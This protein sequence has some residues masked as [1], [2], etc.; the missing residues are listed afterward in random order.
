MTIACLRKS[1]SGARSRSI[2]RTVLFAFAALLCVLVIPAVS[3][4]S[5][6]VSRSAT[7]RPMSAPSR[8]STFTTL[9]TDPDFIDPLITTIIVA[10]FRRPVL[11]DRAPMGCWLRA[12]TFR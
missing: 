5:I 6:T 1:R 3:G 4:S 7:L 12:P 11:R 8:S 2:S 9:F 10:E